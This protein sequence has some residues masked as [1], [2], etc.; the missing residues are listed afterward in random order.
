ME[1][2]K[3]HPVSKVLWVE[4]D[5]VYANDYNPNTVAPPEM[6]LLEH[7][8]KCDGYTQP[9]EKGYEVIDGFHRHI[10]GKKLG[11]SHLPIVVVNKERQERNDRIASTI[12]HNR[13]RGKHR[14][15]AMSDIVLELKNRNWK[16]KRIA[17]ELGMDEDEILRLCQI[18]GLAD[19]FSDE[20]FSRSWDIE[21]SEQDFV[22]LDD[23]DVQD[24]D[25]EVRTVNTKDEKRVFH[26]YDNWECYRAGFYNTTFNGKTKEE[27]YE[28][29]KDF[30]N[31]ET[32][33]RAALDRVI[34][35][36]VKSCEHYLTND[37]LNRI[38]WLGQAAMC[39]ATGVPSEF[40]HGFSL[41]TEEQ[42]G[43][44]NKVALE[45]LNIWL[46]KNNM[47]LT[48]LELGLTNRQSTLY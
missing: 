5:E 38:A 14:I 3:K 15:D 22:P 40:R 10:V 2:T 26:T 6:E 11:L 35:E 42:Q 37:K 47:E 45:Y 18:T 48:T 30:L 31:D 44:A 28:L 32:R 34:N 1:W 4:A 25:V 27:C 19:L 39:Y 21:N 20:D 7:S 23:I 9:I 12:R 36:W 41:L 8:I 33:F 43:K 29:Y 24:G 17:K 46:E 16:N 13:A